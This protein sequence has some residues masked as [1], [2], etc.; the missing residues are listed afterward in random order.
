MIQIN[1]FSAVFSFRSSIRHHK[2]KLRAREDFDTNWARYYYYYANSVIGVFGF[3][4][5]WAENRQ[6]GHHRRYKFISFHL[7][8]SFNLSIHVEIS[9]SKYGH[10]QIRNDWTAVL[11]SPLPRTGRQLLMVV[12]FPVLLSP[13]FPAWYIWSSSRYLCVQYTSGSVH[14][15]LS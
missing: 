4:R 3:A 10:F 14:E 6:Y 2:P 7:L 13:S 15:Y 5:F 12:P 11:W 9:I 8:L 1:L